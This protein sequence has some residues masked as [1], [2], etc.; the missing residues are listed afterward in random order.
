MG[1]IMMHLCISELY[2]KKH[3]LGERFIIGSI[4]PDIYKKTIMSKN[5]SH[6]I[7]DVILNNEIARLPDID[8][9]IK[10]HKDNNDELTI[11]YL[12]HLIEDYV[13]FKDIIIEQV[14]E[15]GTDTKG[16][17]K[18]RYKRENFGILH[19]GNHFVQNI[20]ADYSN[21]DEY[22]LKKVPLDIDKISN[23]IKEFLNS[24][25]KMNEVIDEL[26]TIHKP[27]K[28]RENYFVTEEITNMYINKSLELLEEKINE[29]MN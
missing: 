22:L 14:K 27:I 26:I 4:L 24:D 21:L 11:G 25:E 20:Y 12:A 13:W 7:K 16:I 29:F 1:S 3:N 8:G 28:D 10:M 18:Y 6:Y 15:C 17:F 5:E 2:R 9:Y 19:S 23:N